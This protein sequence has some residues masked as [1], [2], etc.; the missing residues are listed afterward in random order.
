MRVNVTRRSTLRAR[1]QYRPGV[2]LQAFGP[3][4]AVVTDVDTD[5]ALPIEDSVANLNQGMDSNPALRAMLEALLAGGGERQDAAACRD[6]R[7][8]G[9]EPQLDFCRVGDYLRLGEP[10]PARWRAIF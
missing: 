8:D 5:R 10:A 2:H 4:S 3:F 7:I 9:D 1:R 6:G